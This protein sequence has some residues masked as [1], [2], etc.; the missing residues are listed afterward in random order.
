[1]AI[2]NNLFHFFIQVFSN[3]GE[4]S[5][6]EGSSIFCDPHFRIPNYRYYILES[7]LNLGDAFMNEI[8]V[9]I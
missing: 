2:I 8:Q 7:T 3:G 4:N 1:M 6:Y 5:D 9:N